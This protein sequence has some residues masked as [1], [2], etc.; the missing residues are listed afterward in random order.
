MTAMREDH[1]DKI[2][3]NMLFLMENMT[4]VDGVLDYLVEKKIFREPMIEDIR[5]CGLWPCT[6]H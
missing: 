3:E 5:V 4:D 6:S 2:R 1:K